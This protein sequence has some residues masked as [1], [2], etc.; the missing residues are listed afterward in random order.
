MCQ[1]SRVSG[2]AV[3]I[4]TSDAMLTDHTKQVPLC[5]C[6]ATLAMAHFFSANILGPKNTC[7]SIVKFQT[8]KD[9]KTTAENCELTKHD[10][11]E[12][13]D[14]DNAVNISL[15]KL[16]T[17]YETD[18]CVR[19][20]LDL[21][22]DDKYQ[23]HMTGECIPRK[24]MCDANPDCP[25]QDDE[26]NC[27]QQMCA[28]GTTKCGDGKCYV[29]CEDVNI[30]STNLTTHSFD[31]LKP[32]IEVVCIQSTHFSTTTPTTTTTTTTTTTAPPTTTT[33][34]PTATTTPTTTTTTST[35]KLPKTTMATT[36]PTATTTTTTTP[37]LA[38]NIPP[39]TTTASTLPAF[40]SPDISWT[41]EETTALKELKATATSKTVQ[42]DI[43]SGTPQTSLDKTDSGKKSILTNPVALVGIVVGAVACAVITAIIIYAARRRMKKKKSHDIP[44]S[45]LWIPNA[46][47]PNELSS[48][49]T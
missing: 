10:L 6:T 5:Q 45:D 21:C 17:P 8:P 48:M 25:D 20:T 28:E 31:T 2:S 43:E 46:G 33:T 44:P 19:L 35:T 24:F 36:T 38:I 27:E 26:L 9:I 16:H 12:V 49:N 30:T 18:F 11:I 40:E 1:N 4:D 22:L 29:S 3:Y 15:V 34:T 47:E 37:T 32:I 13:R 7:G 42:D 14:E 41:P 23:C 39:R